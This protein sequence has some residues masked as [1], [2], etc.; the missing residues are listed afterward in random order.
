MKVKCIIDNNELTKDKIYEVLDT[1]KIGVIPVYYIMLDNGN[2][3]WV[4]KNNFIT[5]EELRHNKLG[6]LGI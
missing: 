5:I 6:E 2:D 3:G 4:N 1:R